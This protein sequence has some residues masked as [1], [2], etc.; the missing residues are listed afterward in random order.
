MTELTRRQSRDE[1][2]AQLVQEVEA[3]F[4][5]RATRLPA[6]RYGKRRVKLEFLDAGIWNPDGI[7]KV[8][9]FCRQHIGC[10]Y[11]KRI[12]SRVVEQICTDNL[13]EVSS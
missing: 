9:E 2:V 12:A 6:D 5:F 1:L 7:C 10:R 8:F 11:T 3:T 13:K 4:Q